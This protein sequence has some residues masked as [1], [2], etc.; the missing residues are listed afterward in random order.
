M[1]VAGRAASY[2]D[3][4][5]ACK[6]DVAMEDDRHLEVTVAPTTTVTPTTLSGPAADDD[7]RPAARAEPAPAE[8]E[9]GWTIRFGRVA[10]LDPVKVA[11]TIAIVVALVLAGALYL[12]RRQS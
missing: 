1:I 2:L 12:T 6:R 10:R 3:R 11:L 4:Y 5:N 8:V 9:T 7:P